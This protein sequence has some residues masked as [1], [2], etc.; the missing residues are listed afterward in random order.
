MAVY[1]RQSPPREGVRGGREDFKWESL[2]SSQD[3]DYYLGASTK[4][5]LHSRGGRFVKNDWW[6]KQRG[7][8]STT[9]LDEELQRVKNF[10]NELMGEALGQK[11]KNLLVGNEYED[12]KADS[13][14]GAPARSP[15]HAERKRLKKEKK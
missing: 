5:G 10:E 2:T 9:E 3:Y 1:I 11:P 7:G 4:I 8:A 6:T 12:R 15:S 14:D 13:P